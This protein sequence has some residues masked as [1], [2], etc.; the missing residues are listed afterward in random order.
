MSYANT[1]HLPKT[2]LLPDG[3]G[4]AMKFC[5]TTIA[6][7]LRE[8]L[9]NFGNEHCFMVLYRYDTISENTRGH[10]YLEHLT[11]MN[12]SLCLTNI[13]HTLIFT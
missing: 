6:I 11:R 9:D 1:Q 12:I 13:F 2:P 3:N 7:K 4:V 8:M 5:R 10:V